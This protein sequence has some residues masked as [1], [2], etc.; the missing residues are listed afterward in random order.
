MESATL[1]SH[2]RLDPDATAEGDKELLK[3]VARQD[4]RAFE[5]LYRRYYQRISHFVHRFIRNDQLAEEV[6]DDTLFAVWRSAG[7]FRGQSK[8]S[9]WMMGIAYRRAMK[10]LDRERKH[11]QTVA[12]EQLLADQ[13]DSDRGRDPEAQAQAD[14]TGRFLALK[15]QDL[16]PEQRAALQLTALGHSY[17]EIAEIMD[18]PTN[19]VK[20]RVF[21]ARN[22]LKAHFD[23][24][25]PAPGGNHP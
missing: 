17:P 13:A 12:D 6:V 16:K 24:V 19:T 21:Q 18:C 9:T 8:V 25:E 15:L 23:A 7:K 10:T 14:T 22:R 4:K 5:T 2:R 11:L 1:S 3:Q 20:T